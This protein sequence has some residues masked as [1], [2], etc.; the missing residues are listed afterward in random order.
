M[1]ATSL[2][3][4][5]MVLGLVGSAIMGG[6][7]IYSAAKNYLLIFIGVLLVLVLGTLILIVLYMREYHEEELLKLYQ[8]REL[9]GFIDFAC[10][11]GRRQ[12]PAARITPDESAGRDGAVPSQGLRLKTPDEF[13]QVLSAIL[14][15]VRGY[16]DMI[17][18]LMNRLQD[19]VD[20]RL[21]SPGKKSWPPLGIFLFIGSEGVGKHLLARTVT[22]QLFLQPQI[23]AINLQDGNESDQ[24][25]WLF[26]SRDAAGTMPEFLKKNPYG[27]VVIENIDSAGPR[28]LRRLVQTFKDGGY[29][30]GTAHAFVS[31]EHCLVILTTG[32][33]LNLL[34][35]VKESNQHGGKWRESARAALRQEADSSFWPL[36]DLLDDVC[37]FTPMSGM[38]VARVIALLMLRHCQKHGLELRW[39][40]PEILVNEVA[41]FSPQH[42]F[43][44]M[45]EH[46]GKLLEH[47]IR[48][49][50]AEN[51]RVIELRATAEAL[52]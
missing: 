48:K 31:L 3:N 47:D 16:D 19:I 34:V 50:K 10:H 25:T 39:I 32:K 6:V 33:F 23:L 11:V 13:R 26:G 22:Q 51:T 46:L 14:D 35:Q 44:T 40:A 9:K 52:N 2:Y 15:Q 18:A 20:F 21:K 5:L 43:L 41:Q 7:Y 42:G 45:P 24:E 8:R 27:S 17:R 28:V 30:E 1:R 29:H 4:L 38:M 12:R 37:L 49:C 36:F